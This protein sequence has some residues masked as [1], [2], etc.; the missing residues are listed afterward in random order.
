MLHKESA[1]SRFL[2]NNGPD[3]WWKGRR[4]KMET[5]PRLYDHCRLPKVIIPIKNGSRQIGRIYFPITTCRLRKR[6]I[7]KDPRVKN[8]LK[9]APCNGTNLASCR[10][11]F[12]AAPPAVI[13]PGRHSAM[14]QKGIHWG[15][16][17]DC[18]TLFK[19]HIVNNNTGIR[20]LRRVSDKLTHW[21][22]GLQI[23][24]G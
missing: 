11:Q 8:Q 10:K 14:R 22:T 21:T 7:P 9:L 5:K 15:I 13:P 24:W 18:T 23:Q 3:R 6:P 19:N 16:S 20:L 17:L 12:C 1:L 2:E 4:K